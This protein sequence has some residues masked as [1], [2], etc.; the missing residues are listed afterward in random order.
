[1]AGLLDFD[2]IYVESVLV[3]SVDTLLF[4]YN[5]NYDYTKVILLDEDLIQFDSLICPLICDL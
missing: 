2:P 4:H 1:M 3:R 5:C